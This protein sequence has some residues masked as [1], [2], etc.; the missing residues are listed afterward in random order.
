MA[1]YS[2][3]ADP[4]PTAEA[5]EQVENKRE[6]FSPEPAPPLPPEDLEEE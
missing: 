4:L 5:F 3:T 1:R 6:Y 2:G